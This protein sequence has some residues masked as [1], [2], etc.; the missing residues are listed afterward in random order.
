MIPLFADSLA[1]EMVQKAK[2][3]PSE[4]KDLKKIAHKSLSQ[5]AVLCSS[6]V[7]PQTLT[8]GRTPCGTK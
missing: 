1:L 4:V 2:L 7:F 8:L 6:V 3:S 5:Y